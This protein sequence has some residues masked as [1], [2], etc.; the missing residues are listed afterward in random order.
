MY[1]RTIGIESILCIHICVKNF[2]YGNTILQFDTNEN[3]DIS[4][5]VLM[6]LKYLWGELIK[7]PLKTRELKMM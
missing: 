4:V 5:S 1:K 3:I 7:C 2:V 6:R